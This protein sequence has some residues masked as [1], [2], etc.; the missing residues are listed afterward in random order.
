MGISL[1]A[2]K[3]IAAVWLSEVKYQFVLTEKAR[4]MEGKVV[5]IVP[6]KALFS[7]KVFICS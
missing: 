4:Q 5:P 2:L 3:V 6:D 7:P 1:S